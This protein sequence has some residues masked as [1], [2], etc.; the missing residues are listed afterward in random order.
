MTLEQYEYYGKIYTMLAIQ[1]YE[2]GYDIAGEQYANKALYWYQQA[3][4]Y[5]WKNYNF[6]PPATGV[7][8]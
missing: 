5:K 6:T 8:I 1:A 2:L 4:L 3:K 7:L